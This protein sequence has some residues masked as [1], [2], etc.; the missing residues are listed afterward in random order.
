M[1]F[2]A[3]E[4]LIWKPSDKTN[5]VWRVV[6]LGKSPEGPEYLR[7]FIIASPGE[8]EYLHGI[9]R[10]PVHELRSRSDFWRSGLL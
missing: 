6:N 8:L 3:G 1:R 7:C 9:F 2:K 5:R 10:L 4:V